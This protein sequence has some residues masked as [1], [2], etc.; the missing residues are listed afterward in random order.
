MN[1]ARII[2]LLVISFWA[3]LI[4]LLGFI[5]DSNT[6]FTKAFSIGAISS[7]PP[8]IYMFLRKKKNWKKI[9]LGTLVFGVLLGHLL[10]FT[11]NRSLL[12]ECKS[13]IF[14]S[15]IFG[16]STYDC[17]AGYGLMVIFMLT[18][19]EHFLD[20]D[21]NHCISKKV[22]Y[23]LIPGLL[24]IPIS[25]LIYKLDIGIPL[26]S[27]PYTLIG[28]VAIIPLIF[29]SLRNHQI[30]TKFLFLG[31]YFFIY[32]FFFELLAVYKGYWIYE[33]N[34]YIGWVEI[35]DLRFPFEEMFFWMMLFAAT[36]ASYYELFIDDEK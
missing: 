26:T 3:F 6:L 21:L 29:L 33:G 7:I 15:L 23:I 16:T 5:F 30:I 25:Y 34:N 31:I 11:A 14:N 12:W 17:T 27:L 28:T 18:F 32:Y 8:I 22:L 1:Q 4:I 13:L 20:R 9:L 10:E 24:F 19:Y 35:L 36:I 2:D